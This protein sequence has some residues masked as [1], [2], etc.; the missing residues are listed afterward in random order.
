LLTGFFVHVQFPAL[1]VTAVVPFLLIFPLLNTE[2][3]LVYI[4]TSYFV[5]V[6]RPN[7]PGGKALFIISLS[8]VKPVRFVVPNRF[9]LTSGG[10]K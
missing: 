3:E 7:L 10:K 5:K 6:F 4:S 2:G 9:P 1:H 8:D